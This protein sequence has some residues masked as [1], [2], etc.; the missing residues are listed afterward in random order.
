MPRVS[1][2]F[3]RSALIWL[4]FGSSLSVATSVGL[5]PPHAFHASTSHALLVGWITMLIAGVAI[6]MFPNR[7]RDQRYTWA[8]VSWGCWSVGLA[9]RMIGEPGRHLRPEEPVWGG[10]LILS[11]L[12][13]LCGAASLAL[14]LAPRLR[15]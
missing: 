4:V 2:F 11:A 13:Q 14:S 15:R 1:I 7:K 12:C 5:L 10:V 8:W 9:A 3:L 6:W